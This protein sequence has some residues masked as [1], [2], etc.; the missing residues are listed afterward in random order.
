MVILLTLISYIIGNFLPALQLGRH[1]GK[2]ITDEGSGNPGA[3]N[4]GRV[5]G[6]KAFFVVFLLDAGKG[7]L[8][9][10]MAFWFDGRPAILMLALAAVMLGHCYPFVHRF[11]GGKGAATFIGGLL[12]FN[13]TWVVPILI[14]FAVL[15]PF[16]KKF[17][18]ASVYAALSIIPCSFWIY[19]E[20]VTVIASFIVGLL[21][22]TH[23]AN[24]SFQRGGSE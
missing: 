12:V 21:L 1:A 6:K 20:Q 8:A 15:Y 14:T 13:V 10:S 16:I 3:R 7:V 11:K 22:W 4:A 9:V 17:T 24:L 18:A 5:F 23:R 19:D 2:K